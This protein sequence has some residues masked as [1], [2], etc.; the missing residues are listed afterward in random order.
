VPRAR[1]DLQPNRLAGDTPN[2]H[3]EANATGAG[4]AANVRPAAPRGYPGD[5]PMLQRNTKRA[6]PLRAAQE[7]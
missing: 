4:V 1:D 6:G 7:L 2:R 3:V 5:T